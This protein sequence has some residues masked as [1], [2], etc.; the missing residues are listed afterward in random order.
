[1]S[2]PLSTRGRS[3][4]RLCLERNDWCTRAQVRYFVS[5]TSFGIDRSG[6][7]HADGMYVRNTLRNRLVVWS[8]AILTY[9]PVLP[10]P[11]IIIKIRKPSSCEIEYFVETH[12]CKLCVLLAVRFY[13]HD[14]HRADGG[15][16]GC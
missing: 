10:F 5:H 8:T 3:A 13:D 9:L 7:D 11:I 2:P 16:W 14:F 4:N 6:G 15:L 12:I 1:M